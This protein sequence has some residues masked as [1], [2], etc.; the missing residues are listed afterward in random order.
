MEGDTHTDA[1]FWV[2]MPFLPKGSTV[3]VAGVL[4]EALPQPRRIAP[5]HRHLPACE[6]GGL[7]ASV[8]NLASLL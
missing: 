8:T 6:N 3:E 7:W 5:D 2:V 4:R 1:C